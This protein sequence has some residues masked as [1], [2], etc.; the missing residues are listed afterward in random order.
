MLDVKVSRVYLVEKPDIKLKAVATIVLDDCIAIH[1]IKIIDGEGG[2]FIAMPS[3][4]LPNG[5]FKDV[6]HPLNSETREILI[7]KLIAAYEE[8]VKNP[9]TSSADKE[10]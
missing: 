2:L 1:D 7:K 4:K 9:H 10:D 6:A 5:Q 3:R 8:E